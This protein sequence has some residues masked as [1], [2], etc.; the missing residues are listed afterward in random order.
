MY[1][2]GQRLCDKFDDV[3]AEET[4]TRLPRVFIAGR[5]LPHAQREGRA[6]HERLDGRHLEPRL[7]AGLGAARDGPARSCCTP[8]PTSGR[9]SPSSSS[10]S[11][12]SSRRCSARTRPGPAAT[13]RG[14]TRRSSSSTSSPR[15]AS[16]PVSRRSTRPSM[17]TRRAVVPAPR[18]GLPGRDALPLRPGRPAG[19][20]QAGP[21]R[22][23]RP[24][25]RRLAA[26]RLRR[27]QRPDEHAIAP[28]RAVH[29]PGVGRVPD[30]AV[31]P[32]RG[33]PRLGD[34]R[35]RR[36]PAGPPRPRRRRDAVGP[37]AAGRA[38]SA[39]STTRRCSAPTRRPSDIFDLRGV[40]REHR[41]HRRRPADQY[42]A[43][44]SR[45]TGTR[46]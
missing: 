34:R 25:G 45:C 21:P 16:R 10:T 12:A 30:Q 33:R 15:A 40:N 35:P 2:I 32:G 27:P 22:P 36:L 42:V 19:R 6:G 38:S 37:A 9:R 43:T 41:L 17:I 31:H 29:V 26:L 20:R 18:G 46:R 7:E 24:G 8:T 14:S 13:S 4:D 44:C 23:R 1:S 39:W 5:R 3:P 28:P 11:T